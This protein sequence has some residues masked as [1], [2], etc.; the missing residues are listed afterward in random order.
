MPLTAQLPDALR[1][2][3][4]TARIV[5][6]WQALLPLQSCV[7]F[8]N[9]GAHPDDETSAMLAAL[10]H[11]GFD[12][13]YACS[14]RGEG[15]QNDIG[16]CTGAD[17]GALRTAEMER[18]AEALSLRLYWL[19]ETAD[20]PITDFGFSKSGVETLAKWGRE[21]TLARFVHIL[22]RERPDIICPTFL[23][24]PGQHGHHRAMTEAAHLVMDLAA[25]PAFTGSNLAPWQ[26]KKLFL[27]AWSGAGQ[28]YDDDLPPPPATTIVAAKGGDPVTGHS[29]E[30]I[31]QQSRV[32]HATQAMGRWVAPGEE[33]DWPLHLA[34]CRIVA[35]G[36][37]VGA[38][39]PDGLAALAGFAHAPE[40]AQHL[41]AAQDEID[42]CLSAL[43]APDLAARL[44]RALEHVR[45]A[46]VACP[47]HAATEVQHRLARKEQQ[48]SRAIRIAAGVTV[49][50]YLERAMVRPGES[51]RTTVE[52]CDG[53]A[54]GLRVE[55]MLPDGWRMEG[56]RLTVAADAAPHDGYRDTW[57]ADMPDLP[58]L[59]VTTTVEGIDSE[60]RLPLLLPPV[61][62]PARAAD[63]EPHAA[64]LNRQGK[65]RDIPVAINAIF[66][67]KA[68]PALTL[69]EG[70]SAEPSASGILLTAP[71]DVAP[72]LYDIA[73]TLDGEPA[74]SARSISHPHIAPTARTVP[75]RLQV[76]VVDVALP[77]VHVGYI[78]GGNDRVG[79]WLQ[80]LG[81]GVARPEPTRV[82]DADLDKLDTI[83]IGIFAM[84]FREGLAELMPRLHDWIERGGT[85]ITLYHR[86]WD[87]WNPDTIP[88]RR[89]EIG[90]PSLRWR[91]TDETA[92][93][94]HL[95][96]DH[97]LLNTPNTIDAETWA[98]W[99]KE[100][101]LYF[102][103]SWDEA[104]Q[105]LLEMADPEE[106]PMQG[107]LLT[108]D[109]GKG[110]H[111]HTSLI[112]HHQM[113]RL[114]PGAFAL[115]ANLLSKRG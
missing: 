107:A 63:L 73:L 102:A 82:S 103:K 53:T 4:Q 29:F 57:L 104:Y 35:D 80:Q 78:G 95:Q 32:F 85:L 3:G 72:G 40:I 25:D 33:R 92:E 74:F 114:T 20:D 106:D 86:P 48:L 94:T 76:R 45:A 58:S 50:G 66:P 108:A 41:T 18:A 24:I 22:R 31:G 6:L 12:L 30:Q 52:R 10:R 38:G 105:P 69:P 34:D 87:G 19:G 36:D 37:D 88:P 79:H 47:D 11:R 8:M 112:L 67:P 75:A 44:S 16:T 98:G 77:D 84:R 59:R 113:E 17:L 55:W 115:F 97:P 26:V 89:L 7:S 46:R 99:H 27:P 70:W 101:G 64:L 71:G 81:L 90:Q 65:R 2:H 56:D 49:E 51:L 9:T 1:I 5:D 83:V 109:I 110:R 42:A 111:I 39:L 100:R 93:V 61:V 15:G 21:R 54:D 60:T 91:I 13:S 62:L 28:A 43:L 14:T 23:D 96:P 68:E